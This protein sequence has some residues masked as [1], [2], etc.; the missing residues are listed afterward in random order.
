MTL[1][2][3][4]PRTR[5]TVIAGAIGGTVAVA[6]SAFGWVDPVLAGSDGDVVLGA[7]NTAHDVTAITNVEFGT[8]LAVTGSMVGIEAH[9]DGATGVYGISTGAMGVWGHSSSSHGVYGDSNTSYGV[10]GQTHAVDRA[11]TL[12][13]SLGNGTGVQ[14]HSGGVPGLPVGKAKTGVFGYAAQDAT[15]TGVRGESTTGRG[16]VGVASSGIGVRAHA[17]TGTG[18]YVT[19]TTGTGVYVTATTSGYALRTSGR[20]KVEKASGVATIPATK[21]TVVVTPGLDVTTTSFV[22][23][24]PRADI[25]TRRLWY[26]TDATANTITIRVS[27]AVTTSLAVGWL[28]LG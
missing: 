7:E 25:G 5:R 21:S 6:A 17:P 24:T 1:D 9:G 19:T 20:V 8:A 12:G 16:V 22:L 4:T 15:A 14:G 23:L 11:A 10:Y 3:T 13:C 28:L 18:A 2:A 26:T 27:S